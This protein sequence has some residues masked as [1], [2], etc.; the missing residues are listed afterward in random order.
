MCVIFMGLFFAG[1]YPTTVANAS[2][3]IKGSGTAAGIMMSLGGLGG[4]VVP[5]I[6]GVIAEARGMYAGMVVI[7]F[8]SFILVGITFWNVLMGRRERAAAVKR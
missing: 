8:S 7:I 2:L 4:A 1:V 6:N 5:Y 3:L